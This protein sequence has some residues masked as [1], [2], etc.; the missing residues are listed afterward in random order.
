[1]VPELSCVVALILESDAAVFAPL[2]R[3]MEKGIQ[4]TR[5]RTRKPK[6]K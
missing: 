5:R 1:M 6:K 2:V 3:R 4:N